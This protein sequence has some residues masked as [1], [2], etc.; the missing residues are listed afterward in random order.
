MSPHSESESEERFDSQ[1]LIIGAGPGGLAA[2]QALVERDIDFEWFEKSDR[3]GGVWNGSPDS[4]VNGSLQL[5]SSRSMSAFS[6][7]PLPRNGA[8]YPSAQEMNEYLLTFAET[9]GLASRVEFGTEVT[10]IEAVPGPG[11][12]GHNGWAVSVGSR[13]RRYYENVIVATGHHQVPHLPPLPGAFSGRALHSR[14]HATPDDLIAGTVL[15]IGSGTAAVE[16]AVESSRRAERTLLSTRSALRVIPRHMFG[17]PSDQVRPGVASLLPVSVEQSLLGALVKVTAG[18]PTGPGESGTE[19]VPCVSSDFADRVETGGIELRPQVRRLA[20][21]SVEFVDGSREQVD[22]IVYATG[23]DVNIPFLTKDVLDCSGNRLPLYHRVVAPQRPGLWFV[24]F[25]DSFG[26]TIPAL[27]AQAQW[28]GDLIVG[29][30]VLPSRSSMRTWIERDRADCEKRYLDPA[31]HTMQV[32]PWRY[33]KSIKQ[34][35]ARRSG[36][37]R[38]NA[39]ARSVARR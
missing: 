3:I 28:V 8:D 17:R 20:S 25:I 1:C 16:I 9:M 33:P 34:E 36:K 10:A 26:P 19:S 35:R 32:D 29:T 27:E 23:Y 15:V 38:L 21:D 11:L 30:T 6:A 2:A 7:A 12:P 13:P 24:G 39:R 31:C 5:I 22:V 18:Q 14:D 4:P 37:P